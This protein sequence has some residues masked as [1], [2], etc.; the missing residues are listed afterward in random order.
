VVDRFGGFAWGK[1][2]CDRGE[3]FFNHGHSLLSD[4]WGWI[5]N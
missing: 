3:L 4:R 2:E 1:R 5:A